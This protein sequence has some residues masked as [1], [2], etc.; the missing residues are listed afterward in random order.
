[1]WKWVRCKTIALSYV[2]Q[3]VGWATLLL[4]IKCRMEKQPLRMGLH[5][6]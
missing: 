2:C 1:M 4:R 6:V 5:K 3:L